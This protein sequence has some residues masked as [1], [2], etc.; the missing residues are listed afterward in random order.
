MVQFF[1][2]RNGK[3]LLKYDS[4]CKMEN[5]MGKSS[6]AKRKDIEGYGLFY[7]YEICDRKTD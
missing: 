5:T 6:L 3:M 7:I 2:I 4:N 1:Y